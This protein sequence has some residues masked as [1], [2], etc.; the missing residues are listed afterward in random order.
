MVRRGLSLIFV[1]FGPYL[2]NN[3]V[4]DRFHMG[5]ALLRHDLDLMGLP[6]RN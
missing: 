6:S 1:F 2:D 5:Q 4:S 3:Q